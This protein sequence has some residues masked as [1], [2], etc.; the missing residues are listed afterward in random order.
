[1]MHLPPIFFNI[2]YVTVGVIVFGLIVLAI[3]KI[4]KRN[5]R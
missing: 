5:L 3:L 4:R 1:M 2:A